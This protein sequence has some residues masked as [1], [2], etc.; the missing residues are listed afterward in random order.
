MAEE[1]IKEL[2]QRF[3]KYFRDT[4]IIDRGDLYDKYSERKIDLSYNFEGEKYA[5]PE[6]VFKTI[7][8]AFEKGNAE[9]MELFLRKLDLLAKDKVDITAT[10][11]NR[12]PYT[13]S[14]FIPDAKIN[15]RREM[16][17][18]N[19]R[20]VMGYN[21]S[22]I[23]GLRTDALSELIENKDEVSKINFR[24]ITEL[25]NTMEAKE[26]YAIL[27]SDMNA[28]SRMRVKRATEYIDLQGLLDDSADKMKKLEILSLQRY[29]DRKGHVAFNRNFIDEF[30]ADMIKYGAKNTISAYLM[31]LK[32]IPKYLLFGPGSIFDTVQQIRKIYKDKRLENLFKDE[33]EYKFEYK[34]F[35]KMKRRSYYHSELD[36]VKNFDIKRKQIKALNIENIIEMVDF[37]SQDYLSEYKE[38]IPFLKKYR[39]RNKSLNEIRHLYHNLDRVYTDLERRSGRRISDI[40]KKLI[41]NELVLNIFVEK[42]LIQKDYVVVEDIESRWFGL[43]IPIE[44]GMPDEEAL[45]KSLVVVG[46]ENIR[47]LLD[48]IDIEFGKKRKNL[49]QFVDVTS[50]LSGAIDLGEGREE[51][52]ENIAKFITEMIPNVE[53]EEGLKLA[54]K[55]LGEEDE[56]IFQDQPLDVV[57]HGQKY[58]CSSKLDARFFSIADKEFGRVT[59]NWIKENLEGYVTSVEGKKHA[60]NYVFADL[61]ENI[62]KNP[63]FKITPEEFKILKDKEIEIDRSLR[64]HES[65]EQI[66][67]KFVGE[68][69]NYKKI[70]NIIKIFQ[71]NYNIND[72]NQRYGENP[73]I[74]RES[75]KKHEQ[76]WEVGSTNGRNER[77]TSNDNEPND[78]TKQEVIQTLSSQPEKVEESALKLIAELE[79]NDK[80][81]ENEKADKKK[82]LDQNFQAV[83]TGNPKLNIVEKQV[84]ENNFLASA[85]FLPEEMKSCE[86]IDETN[87]KIMTAEESR[88]FNE[89]LLS[90]NYLP[91][92]FKELMLEND[93][94]IYKLH[95]TE[96]KNEYKLEL[97]GVD[98]TNP[99]ATMKIKPNMELPEKERI[100]ILKAL[101]NFSKYDPGT[102]AKMIARAMQ[103]SDIGKIT[104]LLKEEKRNKILNLSSNFGQNNEYIRLTEETK[105]IM[106]LAREN[107]NSKNYSPEKIKDIN[108][109]SKELL[110]TLKK[111][112]IER[113]EGISE[114]IMEEFEKGSLTLKKLSDEI[115][116]KL[117]FENNPL[118]GVFFEKEREK[119]LKEKNLSNFKKQTEKENNTLTEKTVES[120]KRDL[121]RFEEHGK[122]MK[123]EK[124]FENSNIENLR[125][126]EKQKENE[127]KTVNEEIKAEVA[128]MDNEAKQDKELLK[129]VKEAEQSET[130]REKEEDMK[131]INVME[132][133]EKSLQIDETQEKIK[134]LQEEKKN[135]E[136]LESEKEKTEDNEKENK[137]LEEKK[138]EEE[139]EE[140][141]SKGISR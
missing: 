21:L 85:T 93:H 128:E 89:K 17:T 100:N 4:F 80:I 25:L 71:K 117:G 49:K 118:E 81:I 69:E 37:N 32:V 70:E 114:N 137:I 102:K 78:L 28:F 13:Q 14:V 101:D 24:N 107:Y 33:E 58:H 135:L 113:A 42:E 99:F 19:G 119:N 90:I 54:E 121:Q 62:T 57:F 103:G 63:N 64:K 36:D 26:I 106:R 122:K 86:E 5:T 92:E 50:D 65:V 75:L 108:L 116:K 56:N 134:N 132:V 23:D 9:E 94:I 130:T 74:G 125:N 120:A 104:E 79:L 27:N 109:I 11:S 12:T 61:F 55:I 45:S 10:A 20:Y 18:V 43:K 126:N 66:M 72:I 131:A 111:D 112:K 30:V 67:E 52:I 16:A 96:I 97:F 77:F 15:A 46:Q 82:N 59:K 22:D 53:W 91:K 98:K 2:D 124:I 34:N 76:F 123:E 84:P 88:L 68:L 1:E 139:K 115:S 95:K 110:E 47:E 3:E 60:Y 127:I 7:K 40:T 87:R 38:L 39:L 44:N 48:E 31:P 105:M 6:S 133:L 29:L 140:K 8:E 41:R 129:T 138:T 35:E 73:V 141:R 136:K 83:I 51:N